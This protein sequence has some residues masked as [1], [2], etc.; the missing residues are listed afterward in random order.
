MI[1][2]LTNKWIH[3]LVL[4]AMLVGAVYFSGSN[5]EIRK[6]LQ[7]A[8]FDTYNKLKPRD[9]TDKI[10]IIDI[11]EESLKTMGQWPWSRSTMAQLIANLNELGAKVI[12]FDIVF[13]E[14][15][16]TSPAR[17]AQTLPQ[18][19]VYDPV[20]KTLE[21]LPDNDQIFAQ[22]IEQAGNIVTGFTRAR[23]EETLRAPYLSSEPTFL[24]KDKAPFYEETFAAPGIAENLSE[25]SMAAAGNGSF[26]ATPDID[27]IIREISLMVRYP[28]EKKAGSEPKLYPMLGLETLRVNVDKNARLLI[29]PSPHKGAFD[30]DYIIKVADANIPVESD[31]KMWVYYRDIADSEYI[32]AQS[33]FNPQARE[34][35]RSRIQD[36]L[37]FV[38][39]SAEAF[40]ISVLH[41]WMFSFPE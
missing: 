29:K 10:A 21:G 9:A 36:K 40:V 24:M 12:A 30:M 31:A 33:L 6:R 8:T 17:I 34:A 19:N 26:M 1:K 4:F 39:T 7:Y 23:P 27:G 13:A 3:I 14:P 2:L 18:D 20:K 37:V 22:A 16:R 32:S 5:H 15:D 41:H 35:L 11:D 28:P 25:F 38:G